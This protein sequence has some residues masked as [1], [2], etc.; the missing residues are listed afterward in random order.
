VLGIQ[1]ENIF[2]Q[3]FTGSILTHINKYLMKMKEK[4]K[5]M[6]ED[7][8]ALADHLNVQLHLGVVETKD[9]FEKQKKNL[10]AW[11]ESESNRLHHIKDISEEHALK[12]KSSIEELRVQASLGKADTKEKL[13]E[14]QK[15]ITKKIAQL[16]AEISKVYD[17]LQV[18][19]DSAS[20]R[21]DEKLDEF[22]TRFDLIRIQL[23]LGKE[24][25]KEVWEQ[26]KKEISAKLHQ[27]K[28][29]LE[30]EGEK[31]EEKFDQFSNEISEKWKQIR[32]LT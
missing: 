31:A 4:T 13:E 19:V 14:Q 12:L 28:T 8:K 6:I 10:S 2:Q 27:I 5:K 7:W 15:K 1:S 24:E 18:D 25:T 30:N 16:K 32:D 21:V 3:P 9:E 17:T 20:E 11:L 26:K 29:N 22:H 23:H